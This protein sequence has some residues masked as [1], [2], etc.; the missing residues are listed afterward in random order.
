MFLDGRT[1]IIIDVNP[2]LLDLLG[3]P[4]DELIGKHLSDLGMFS[5][6]PES[7]AAFKALQNKDYVRY[8]NL[9]LQTRGA[10]GDRWRRIHQQCLRCRR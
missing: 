8:E 3:Y 1:D 2:Y 7:N 10:E 5:D 9:P 4:S 6:V